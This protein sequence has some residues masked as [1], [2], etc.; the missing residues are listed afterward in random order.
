MCV[1]GQGGILIYMAPKKLLLIT[2]ILFCTAIW[3]PAV[4]MG[5]R[6]YPEFID[7]ENR[8]L[9]PVPKWNSAT[10]IIRQCEAYVDDHFGFRPDLIRWNTI[11]RIR[12]FGVAPA[13]S[14]IVGKDSWL[15]YHSE[16]LGDGNEIEDH[17]G[18]ITLNDDA[19][20]KLR[21]RL[22]ENSRKFSEKGIVY[23]PVIAPNKDTIYGEFLPDRYN[24]KA[25]TSRLRQFLAYMKEHSSLKVL[26]LGNALE[27]AKENHPVYWAT[28][29]HWNSFGAYIG[30]REIMKRISES[31]PG[32]APVPLAGDISV[33]MRQNGGDLAQILF[34]QD[35]WPEKNNTFLE[36]EKD[37][38]PPS[39]KKLVFRHDSF[40][41]A[42]YPYLGKHF[43][44]I[45][46]IPPFVPFHF[47]KIFQE[48]PEV[49]L[50]I[51][52]ER[53]LTRAIHDDFYYDDRGVN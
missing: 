42:L 7:A 30:Y 21:L 34:I 52:V 9:A 15:F 6:F 44:K 14:V 19:L 18:L 38:A 10:S 37:S 16:T 50:H 45:L 53:Y 13:S 25:S 47:E 43:Q 32:V 39:F 48:K 17:M 2:V 41:D 26:Y 51:F 40:G 29:S 27:E 8:E 23:I 1:V 49:V 12:L 5:F 4:Q 24:N 3:L 46:N 31:F 33:K 35:I 11:L 22:E 36:L 28:D 20:E